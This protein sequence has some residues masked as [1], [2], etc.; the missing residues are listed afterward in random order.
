MVG[1]GQGLGVALGL[2]VDPPR[3]D[4]VDV[5]PVGLGLGVDLRV[6]VDLAGRGEHEPCPLVARQAQCLVGAEAPDLQGLDGQLEVVDRRRRRGPV[7][8]EVHRARD[9][10]V[11]GHVVVQELEPVVAEQVLDVVG[12]AGRQV[13]EDDHP[14]PQADQPAGQVGPEEARPPGDDRRGTVQD[15]EVVAHVPGG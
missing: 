1:E 6:A 7:Q 4:G 10:E 15:A 14:R 8:H 13:V 9:V 5:A 12:P 11:L 2:V 3:A